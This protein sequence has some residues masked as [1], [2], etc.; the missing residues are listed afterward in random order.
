MCLCVCVCLRGP[1]KKS[2]TKMTRT[3]VEQLR[4]KNRKDNIKSERRPHNYAGM[5]EFKHNA[6]HM[7][8]ESSGA[9][10]SNDMVLVDAD[11]LQL[12]NTNHLQECASIAHGTS[13][14]TK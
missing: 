13:A 10:S 8:C 9:T 4:S 5:I 3:G 2:T 7:Q 6:K 14:Q 12:H 1:S 11:Q